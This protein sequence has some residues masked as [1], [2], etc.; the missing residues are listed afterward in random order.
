VSR[1]S[2]IKSPIIRA[3]IVSRQSPTAVRIDATLVARLYQQAQASRWGVSERAF[4]AAL[5]RSA[6]RALPD[7][8]QDRQRLERH[9]SSLHLADLALACACAD[10]HEAAW[11]HFVREYRP[12]LY[13]SADAIDPTGG[14]RELAD[15]IY[16]DLFGL[17]ERDGQRRSLLRYFHG[18]SSLATWL[19]AVLAQRQVDR[20]RSTR[21]LTPLEA[22]G[23]E[24]VTPPALVTAPAAD[25]DT[26]RFGALI[27]RAL[28]SALALLP[29]RDRLRL[30][31]Y[32]RQD[33]TLAQTGRLLGEHEATVSRQLTR[34]RKVI[35]TEVERYL[36]NECGLNEAEIAR[37]F[38]CTIEDPGPLDVGEL[39][40]HAGARKD[41]VPRRS[42]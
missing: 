12:V 2:T 22:A 28:A 4:T 23:H 6:A 7:R 37:C 24:E 21:R 11:D 25:P 9:L 34:T 13:R 31:C 1:R 18:R 33:L 40:S 3:R 38:E 41:A 39:F 17:Q 5:E 26:S 29:D 27:R 15:S 20:V 8:P 30:G 36:G 42:K 14:A 10:G 19:R 16:A 32:Y 35:R